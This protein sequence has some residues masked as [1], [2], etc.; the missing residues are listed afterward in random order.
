MH[1]IIKYIIMSFHNRYNKNN[2]RTMQQEIYT[3][4]TKLCKSPTVVIPS[5]TLVHYMDIVN[6]PVKLFNSSNIELIDTTT[7]AAVVHAHSCGYKNIIAMNFAS[8]IHPGGGYTRG[9]T[10]QEE[11]WCRCFPTLYPSLSSLIVP[12]I[13]SKKPK[14]VYPFDKRDAIVTPNVKLMRSAST[15]YKMLDEHDMINTYFVSAAAPNLRHEHYNECLVTATLNTT[16][17]A[18]IKTFELNT[19]EDNCLILGAWGCGAFRC[20]PD[21]I[22]KTIKTAVEKYGGYYGKIIFAIPDSTGE[23]YL[24]FAKTF[25]K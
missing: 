7:D 18:P 1:Y 5:S 11:D 13:Y 9:S 8:N 16:F 19:P 17:I 3:E 15:K 2:K 23:N 20:D 6:H 24:S 21:I 12:D 14:S 25:S 22:S 4:N 10:A